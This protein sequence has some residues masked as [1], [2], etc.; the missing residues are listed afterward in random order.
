MN[1]NAWM[2]G[3]TASELNNPSGEVFKVGG[4]VA[5]CDLPRN[6]AD[7]GG[8]WVTTTAM[9]GARLYVCFGC[10]REDPTRMGWMVKEIR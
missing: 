3:M 5:E 1:D 4:W 8:G 7:A 10:H 6:V 2:R 9:P